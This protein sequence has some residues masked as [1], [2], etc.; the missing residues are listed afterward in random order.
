VG[1]MISPEAKARCEHLIQS[2]ID[3]GAQVRA[4]LCAA[5]IVAAQCCDNSIVIAI[6]GYPNA[7]SNE[8]PRVCAAH[9]VSQYPC[10]HHVL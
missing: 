8:G 4:G 7:V 6:E 2:G 9:K 5:V 3:E 1:P 10:H